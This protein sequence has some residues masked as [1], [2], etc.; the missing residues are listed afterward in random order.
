LSALEIENVV[1]EHPDVAEVAVCGVADQAYGQAVAAVVV[2]APG[3]ALPDRQLREWCRE[4]M[5]LYKV[6]PPLFF[7]LCPPLH[8]HCCMSRLELVGEAQG[9]KEP[10]QAFVVAQLIAFVWS[11]YAEGYMHGV[12]QPQSFQRLGQLPSS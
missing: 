10:G 9:S 8:P 4:R 5:A 2:W 11:L 12:R 1:L 7:W 3:R 6:T